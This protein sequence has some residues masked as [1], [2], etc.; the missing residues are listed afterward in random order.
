[1]EYLHILA[2]RLQVIEYLSANHQAKWMGQGGPDAWPA[3]TPDLT[4]LDVF[5]EKV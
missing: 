1:M 4:P 3:R 2:D 5:H